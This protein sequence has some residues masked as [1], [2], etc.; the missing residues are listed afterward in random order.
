MGGT[1]TNFLVKF[2]TRKKLIVI[3]RLRK[4]RESVETGKQN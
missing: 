2:Y 1:R 4:K 3:E